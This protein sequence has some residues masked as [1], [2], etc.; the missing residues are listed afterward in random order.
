MNL[1]GRRPKL[2][3]RPATVG[4]AAIH[5]TRWNNLAMNRTTKIALLA[6][7]LTGSAWAYQKPGTKRSNYSDETYGVALDAPQFPGADSKKAGVAISLTGPPVGGF[8][9]NINVTINPI[10]TTLKAFT[11]VTVAECKR[12]NLTINSQK[13]IKVSG[14][15]AL[16]I[17]YEG[18]LNV[19][20]GA[21]KLRFLA[22]SVIDKDRVL[23]LT[24]TALPEEFAKAEPE[25]RACLASFKVR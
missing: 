8:A 11:D 2:G 15:D 13:A 24:C 5:T 19:M 6:V 3:R 12:L 21:K 18:T 10:A 1:A 17:D 4:D 14:K 16:E 25:F 7:I 22:L 23:V 9:S 20:N